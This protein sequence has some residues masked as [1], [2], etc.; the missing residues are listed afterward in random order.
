MYHD[1]S[2]IKTV[3]YKGGRTA[4]DIIIF[5]MVSLHAGQCWLVRCLEVIMLMPS[6]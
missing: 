6:L 2:Q 4:A 3:D 5:A 1:G